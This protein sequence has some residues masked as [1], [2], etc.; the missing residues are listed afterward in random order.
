[1]R[2]KINCLYCISLDNIWG[3]LEEM[4]ADVEPDY[5]AL[6]ELFAKPDTSKTN[7]EEK[8]CPQEIV[9]D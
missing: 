2:L 7:D 6:D 4:A 1:M 3:S 9:S 5:E 8:Q